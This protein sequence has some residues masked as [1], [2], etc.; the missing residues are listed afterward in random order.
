MKCHASLARLARE[1][2]HLLVHEINSPLQLF[3][4]EFLP[5]TNIGHGNK[6]RPFSLFNTTVVIGVD[7]CRPRTTS[8]LE[9]LPK[10]GKIVLFRADGTIGSRDGHDLKVA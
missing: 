3:D 1:P 6:N 2:G 5:R 9:W 8:V 7:V 10:R 4:R